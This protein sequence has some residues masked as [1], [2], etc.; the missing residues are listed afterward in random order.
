MGKQENSNI[1]YKIQKSKSG[2]TGKLNQTNKRQ[3]RKKKENKA[4]WKI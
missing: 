1:I 4:M 2:D 3:E